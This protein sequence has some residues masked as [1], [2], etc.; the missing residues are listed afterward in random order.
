MAALLW[1]QAPKLSS[2]GS[3]LSLPQMENAMSAP[4]SK[5]LEAILESS[6]PGTSVLVDSSLPDA[7]A[8]PSTADLDGVVAAATA[9]SPFIPTDPTYDTSVNVLAS[10]HTPEESA[11]VPD[12]DHHADSAA[13]A[14]STA[15]L[16]AGPRKTSSV[17]EVRTLHVISRTSTA[18]SFST[19]HKTRTL[20]GENLAPKDVGF[21]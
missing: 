1:V 11:V 8:E 6:K 2:S 4:E 15:E 9:P 3:D 18:P 21:L 12:S 13:R 16:G 20:V 17:H 19:I 10:A 7:A 5:S 14:L